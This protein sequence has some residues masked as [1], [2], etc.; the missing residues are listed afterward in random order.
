[1]TVAADIL[2]RPFFEP[3][4]AVAAAGVVLGAIAVFAYV[5]TMRAHPVI[6]L[7]L[8]LMRLA[9]VAVITVLLM[10]PSVM[11]ES[12]TAPTRP[13]LTIAVD[14]SGSMARDDVNG[15]TRLDFALQQW[16]NPERLEALA[17]THDLAFV[18]LGES[19]RS[20]TVEALSAE[21]RVSN[22]ADSVRQVVNELDE[23]QD[24]L[25]VVV[26]SDGH[27][28]ASAPFAA[29]AE[30]ARARGAAV[31]TVTL[32][33]PDLQQD[34]A[35]AATPMQ[36]YLLKGESGRI[37]VRVMQSGA[38]REQTTVRMKRGEE[39]QTFPVV[40]NGQSSVTLDIPIREDAVG[41]YEYQLSVDA[42]PGESEQRNNHQSVFMD[43]TAERFKVLILEGEPYWDTKYLAQTLRK[44]DRI[45]L[46]QF[47]QITP[48]RRQKVVTRIEPSEA[49]FPESLEDLCRYDV[50]VLG[51]GVEQLLDV[52]VLEQLPR[53]VGEYGGRVVFSR[54]RA[55]DA[56]TP[57][58]M[59]AGR[60][61]EV[62]EPV[63]WGR[64]VLR[65]Q[66]LALEN[67]GVTHPAFAV[68]ESRVGGAA[69]LVGELPALGSLPVV[70]REKTLT[71]VLA[72]ARPTGV[73]G[74]VGR[75]QAV[76]V[77]MPYDRGI[78]AGV[79]GEGLWKWSLA[80]DEEAKFTG[81]FD[82]FWSN[83]VRWAAMGGE[84]APGQEVTLR[85]SRQNVQVGDTINIEVVRRLLPGAEDRAPLTVTTPGG[86]VANPAL[87]SVGGG[88]MRQR[89][90]FKPDE[91]GVYVASIAAPNADDGGEPK[92][93]EARFNVYDINREMLHSAADPGAMRF[94]AEETGGVVLD[95][96]RPGE[97]ADLLAREQAARVVPPQP[98][99]IWDR[100]WVLACLL[101]WAGA[102]WL[103][104]KKGG[105]L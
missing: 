21:A 53:Y 54:G 58:G 64:G 82:R 9:L 105:L 30:L 89:A 65:D 85:L 38:G 91:A 48:T 101:L 59:R 61:L 75:G 5:R 63:V 10:G 28:T 70:A 81:V 87:R 76:I 20:T 14:N 46:V 31:H 71:R 16:L 86:N 62:I 74:G 3:I 98:T 68:G 17:R 15:A 52:S 8:L 45:E 12:S 60:A 43:V 44:D 37:A 13:T 7:P 33:G 84:F 26:I 18:A 40:F 66:R 24:G 49:V 103:L 100:G 22:L 19:A 56:S 36:E 72:R 42:L 4:E 50:I 55:Y 94:L 104:R 47:T 90:E 69:R 80:A 73:G 79:L 41:R 6:A 25:T 11:P 78:V 96:F 88:T 23:D 32:G 102:E 95:P 29:A 34:V 97:L 99:Y 67:D 57:A 83:L 1:M 77:T 93:V 27:D 39:T 51:K 92:V 35:L 2:W